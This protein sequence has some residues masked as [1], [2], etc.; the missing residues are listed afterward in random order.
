MNSR[1]LLGIALAAT[2]LY[3]GVL[4][5]SASAELHRVQ[6]TLVTGQ[7]LTVTVDVPAGT[8]VQQVQIPGLPAPVQN[9]VDLGP[10]ATPTPIPTPTV[11]KVP[12]LPDVKVP[13]VPTP[14][15]QHG[16]GDHSKDGGGN[17]G[18]GNGSTQTQVPTPDENAV[19]RADGNVRSGAGRAKDKARDTVDSTT[20][21]NPDGS[22]SPANPTFSLSTPGPARIGVPNFFINKFRIPPFLLPIYQA[23]GIQYGVRWE[24]LAAINEI[25]TD[26]G[27]NLN[28]STAGAVG[29]MQFLPSTWRLYGVDANGDGVKDP[30]N[31]VDAIFAAARYLRA[32]GADTDIRRAV[33]AYNHADWYVDSVLLRAQVIGGLPS[34][35]V[36]S[37]TG[38]TQ[39]RFPVQARATY[40]GQLKSKTKKVRQG[41]AAMLVESTNRRGIKIFSRDGAPV[42]AVNDGRIVAIGTTKRLGNY[43]KLQDV[44]GNTYTYGH[45]QRIAKR[46]P[47]PKLQ[48]A[49]QQEDEAQL[50][51]RDAAPSQPASD[52][53]K[54]AT[55]TPSRR[56]AAKAAPKG[57]KDAK[58]APATKERLFANPTR[59]NA[60]A[61]GGAN[62]EFQRTGR[63]DGV[64]SF[65]GYYSRILGLDRKDVAAQAP[66]PRRPRRGRHDPRP[67]RQARQPRAVPE[68]RDP[69]GRPRRPARGSEADPRRLEAARVDRDLP[70]QRQEPLLRR[71]RR[72]PVDRPDPADEQGGARPPR[73]RQPADRHLRVR[74]PGHPRGPDRPPR[75]GDPRVPRRL[76]PAADGVDAQVRPQLP[77][78]V[79]QRVRAH[80]R[81]SR[82]HRRDQRDPDPSATRARARSPR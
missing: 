67:P 19:N 47:V 27:R 51:Q 32:A 56:L 30:Y 81:H 82:R 11:P 16:G 46:Y 20:G 29:W 26:Y 79:G 23:A 64:E 2:A 3:A 21:T 36:G 34:N 53:A 45:L 80:H 58:P 72:Q 37:L 15:N 18:G 22:P 42:V 48:P 71:R 68:V 33:F 35:L 4:V 59:P 9:I 8:P 25:E 13:S 6:V 52:T 24:V 14:G 17:T 43:I 55:K 41:N 77:D 76:R 63:I 69:P 60:S 49:T 39:G 54:P 40:A 65:E 5:A 10:V 31:P 74:P 62:Q 1:K 50:P 28:V 78:D 73:A 12:D 66:A 70:R 61:A 38:L 57:R 75:A 44:Y 7:V